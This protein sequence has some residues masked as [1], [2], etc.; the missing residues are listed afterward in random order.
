MSMDAII[1]GENTYYLGKLEE[2]TKL[3]VQSTSECMLDP[4]EVSKIQGENSLILGLL[5]YLAL[6]TLLKFIN[7]F[8]FRLLRLFINDSNSS[9]LLLKALKRLFFYLEE[10][11]HFIFI[12]VPIISIYFYLPKSDGTKIGALY[13]ALL[14]TVCVIITVFLS[15]ASILVMIDVKDCYFRLYA[16]CTRFSI[17]MM[18]ILT[19]MAFAYCIWELVNIIREKK[20]PRTV[21]ENIYAVFLVCS[22]IASTIAHLSK[23]PWISK[24][25]ESFVE[26]VYGM[27]VEDIN[28]TQNQY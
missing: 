28:I 20:H 19:I 3:I 11:A 16:V 21:P 1:L 15:I 5:S 8:Q 12:V 18:Y 10:A 26:Q 27:L 22:I 7:R 24:E 13:I 17:Y 9:L 6:I 25:R 14:F 2:I 23:L 4:R